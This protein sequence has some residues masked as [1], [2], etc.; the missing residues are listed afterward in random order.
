MLNLDQ[1]VADLVLEHSECAAI[2]RRHRIDYCCRGNRSIETACTERGIDPGALRDELAGAIAE[3]NAAPAGDPRNLSSEAL[4]AHI[5]SR[6]HD[7]LRWALPFLQPLAAKVS[8]VH[9]DQKPSLH[10]L[11]AL[12]RELCEAMLPHIDAE[13]QTLFPTLIAAEVDGDGVRT[14]LAVLEREHLLVGHL[15][16]RI[17]TVAEGFEPPAWACNSYRTLMAELAQ[18]EADTLTHVHL[19][20]HVLL[21]RFATG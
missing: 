5:T 15:L 8:R 18:L 21:P 2:F 20:N 3:R 11:A 1:N 10:Q 13:D 7:Y 14:A 6:H 9:G 12:V 16:D 19:E 4:I 17:R